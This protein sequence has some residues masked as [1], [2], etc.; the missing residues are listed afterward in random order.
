MRMRITLTLLVLCLGS[1]ALKAQPNTANQLGEM[2]KLDFL[3]G[4]WKGTGYFEFA[5]GQRRTFTETENVQKKLGGLVLLIEGEGKS[6]VPGEEK[7]GP[8]HE[9]LALASYDEP[10]KSFKWYAYRAGSGAMEVTA[11]VGDQTLEWGFSD[12]R[13]GTIRFIITLNAKGQWFETG[14]MSR[15]GGNWRKFFEMTLDRVS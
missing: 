8:V 1:I 6:L 2:R 15:E 9:A 12:P 5:P 4:S 14:E 10:S 7:Q 3:V 11:K 13:A